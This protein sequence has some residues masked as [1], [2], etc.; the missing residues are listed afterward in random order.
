MVRHVCL[1]GLPNIQSNI[2]TE[3]IGMKK[4]KLTAMIIIAT[5]FVSM[6][7]AYS[8]D[9]LVS[10]AII[11][12]SVDTTANSH[13]IYSNSS[14]A[15]LTITT[16]TTQEIIYATLYSKTSGNKLSISSVPG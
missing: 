9:N 8:A 5:I 6:F 15:T 14:P 1:L 10:A 3:G 11:T 2:K 16:S 4:S 13:K 7:M 12:P